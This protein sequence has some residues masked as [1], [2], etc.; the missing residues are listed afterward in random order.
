ML[1]VLDAAHL[2]KYV[3]SPFDQRGGLMLVGPPA[4]L[5]TTLM[6]SVMEE[7]HDALVI[8]DINIQTL[9][10]LR[11]DF[12]SGRYST[13]C[14]TEFS[15][16][17]A[18]RG[19]TSANLEMA[20]QGLVEEGFTV[21]SFK[22]QRLQSGKARC[23]VVGAMV[24]A[25]YEDNYTAWEASGFLRRFL[26]CNIAVANGH[27]LMDAVHRW[28][29]LDLGTYQSKSP[30]NKFIKMSV[31]EYESASLQKALRDQPGQTTPFV[32]LKKILS[33]LHWKYDKT[34]PKRAWEIMKDFLPCLEKHGT[35]IVLKEEMDEEPIETV[36][37]KA[38]GNHDKKITPVHR[39]KKS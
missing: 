26:W 7:H 5:K 9:M 24:E 23:L 31:T 37:E 19:E 15:K 33:V 14:F 32:L 38:T 12:R 13:L 6:S 22:D 21:P 10:K 3:R 39:R 8:G 27:L 1:E 35:E 25:F 4:T 17:Y 29:L 34:E 30:G 36:P 28:E 18:R 11:S 2:S 20:I 16:L